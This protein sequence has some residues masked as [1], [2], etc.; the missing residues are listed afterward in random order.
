MN[1]I[2]TDIRK[3]YEKLWEGRPEEISAIFQR[4]RENG[5]HFSVWVNAYVSAEDL[6]SQLYKVAQ[7]AE[8]AQGHFPTVKM[9]AVSALQSGAGSFNVSYGMKDFSALL[10]KTARSVNQTTDWSD[11]REIVRAIH[12]YCVRM[13][14]YID[15]VAPWAKMSAYFNEVMGL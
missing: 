10:A 8:N 14:Y 6:C 11:L 5:K 12:L 15:G 13:W 1:E 9:F 4:N 3:E 7:W 2:V